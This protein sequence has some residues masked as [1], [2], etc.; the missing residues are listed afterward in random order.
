[1]TATGAVASPPPGEVDTVKVVVR[2]RPMNASEKEAR[3]ANI[4][5]IDHINGSIKLETPNDAT[6]R[7]S[8]PKMFTFDTVF[9]MDST[10]LDVYNRV[11]REGRTDGR[12]RFKFTLRVAF[13][14][15]EA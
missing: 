4:V 3:Y 9:G 6:H 12:A 5:Q 11:A 13:V 1:M 10:Q 7:D 8:P 2:V 14:E 15:H